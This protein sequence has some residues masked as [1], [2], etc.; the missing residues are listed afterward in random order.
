MSKGLK[1]AG[2]IAGV[3]ATFAAGVMAEKKWQVSAKVANLAK[4]KE[5]H[6]NSVVAQVAGTQPQQPAQQANK[7]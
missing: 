2:I 6:D 1:T 4:K 5:E 7:A 3:A